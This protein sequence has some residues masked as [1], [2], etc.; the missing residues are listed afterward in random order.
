MGYF[1]GVD[2]GQSSTKSIIGDSSGAILGQGVSGPCN[3]VKSGDGRT[4]FVNALVS[5][6]GQALEQA[7][8]P[9]H[10]RQFDAACL[11][12][13]GGP[14]DKESIVRELIWAYH[15][16]VTTDAHAALYGATSA[17]PGIIVISGTGSIALG[18]ND[19][20]RTARAG[21]WGYIFGDEGSAFDIARQ[22][23]RAILRHQEGW[24]P[25]TALTSTLLEATQTADANQLMHAFYTDEYPRSRVATFARLVDHVASHG[26][27]VAT[28]ILNQ[29]ARD[30]HTF[31]A[32]VRTQ[33]FSPAQPVL[34]CPI[35]NTFQSAILRHHFETLA[36]L[37]DG[38]RVA[39][40]AFSPA[41][42]ALLEAYRLAG[43][44]ID[45]ARFREAAR[46]PE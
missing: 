3:H 12:F 41:Q 24:G 28:Q 37:A 20:L 10:Q 2:G 4:K 34:I 9:I 29:A 40:P 44:T 14:A 13:S 22:A 32:A 30:L 36:L 19:Q 31:V 45:L 15:L 38:A 7:G 6:V 1:L 46:Q 43:V 39:D 11:G 17:S 25:P 42:G 27:P 16:T 5:S 23:L 8:L 26:D 18:R 33:L 35:G 21:G